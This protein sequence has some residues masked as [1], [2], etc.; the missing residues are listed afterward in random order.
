MLEQVIYNRDK[1]VVV[2]MYLEIASYDDK[3]RYKRYFKLD[4]TMSLMT[5]MINT[6]Q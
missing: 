6:S 1:I 3:K 5:F 2:A 4:N